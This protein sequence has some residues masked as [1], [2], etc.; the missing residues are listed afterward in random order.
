M[1]LLLARFRLRQS[2]ELLLPLSISPRFSAVSVPCSYV[3]SFWA[4]TT[5]RAARCVCAAAGMAPWLLQ[6]CLSSSPVSYVL[7]ITPYAISQIYLSSLQAVESGKVGVELQIH[8]QS[9]VVPY[10]TMDCG[11]P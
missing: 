4:T 11:M 1:P 5:T 8:N 10:P 3:V 6:V 9:M 7:C 2:G